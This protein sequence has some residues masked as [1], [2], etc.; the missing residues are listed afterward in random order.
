[1]R[2]LLLLRLVKNAPG[3]KLSRIELARR[4]H[5]SPSTVTRATKP[6]EKIGLIDREADVR[7]A[8]LSYVVLSA[9]GIELL[10]YADKTFHQLCKD[11]LSKRLSD[12]ELARLESILHKL[13]LD[14]SGS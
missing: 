2:D 13:L 5:V 14:A 9:A 8:R 3:S 10:A 1:M 7:D 6:L 12:D 4:L 11:Y